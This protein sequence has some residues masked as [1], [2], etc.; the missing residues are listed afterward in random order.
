MT[1]YDKANVTMVE[2]FADGPR[3]SGSFCPGG[4]AVNVRPPKAVRNT[5]IL[6]ELWSKLLIRALHREFGLLGL[7]GGIQ[8]ILTMAHMLA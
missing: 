3:S 1:L 7:R 4:S 5:R 6:D 8:E 2:D